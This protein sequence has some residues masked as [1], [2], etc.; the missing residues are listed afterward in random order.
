MGRSRRSRGISAGL[1]VAGSAKPFFRNASEKRAL[2][3][4]LADRR[5]NARRDFFR[6]TP[7][8]A[9]AYFALLSYQ[10]GSPMAPGTPESF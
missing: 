7:D 6:L 1:G 10:E 5:V 4:M 3:A 9:P 2:Y 8:E